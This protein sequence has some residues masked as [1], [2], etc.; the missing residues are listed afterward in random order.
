MQFTM[1]H[2]LQCDVD[3]FWE[4]IFFDPEFN[5]KL[6]TQGLEFVIY[7]QLELRDEPAARVRRMRTQPK[8]DVPL[9]VRKLLGDPVS[10]EEGRFDKASKLWSFQITP[11]KLADKIHISGS[12]RLEPTATGADRV[13]SARIDVSIFGVGGI[14]E[15]FIEKQ[16]RENY[17]K[18]ATFTNRYLAEQGLARK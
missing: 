11:H 1:R 4:K 6:F 13:T 17:D 7:E 9:P 14:F 16:L 5:R 10:I 18:S 15:S 2:P 8:G 12:V 3:T